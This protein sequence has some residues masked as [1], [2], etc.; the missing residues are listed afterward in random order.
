M[1]E[2]VII[3]LHGFG[4]SPGNKAEF[5]RNNTDCIV[6]APHLPVNTAEA[7]QII[8]SLLDKH[9][10]KHIHIVGTSLGGFYVLYVSLLHQDTATYFHLINAPLTPHLVLGHHAG[11][12]IAN[13]KTGEQQYVSP[14]FIQSLEEMSN[15]IQKNVHPEV[16]KRMFLYLGTL[17]D[18]V[19]G[20][21]LIQFLSRFHEPL[22][23]VREEQ[24]HR[25]GDLS[26]VVERIKTFIGIGV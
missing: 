3:S 20:E 11:K 5:L 10:G 25:F 18:V 8:R 13:F 7:I 15:E 19:D 12:T 22:Q 16:L 14:D 2:N 9:K 17:D 21:M 24:D 26:C 23:V 1:T 6:E 4:S